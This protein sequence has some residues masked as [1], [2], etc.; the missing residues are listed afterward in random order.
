M[1][2]KF[3]YLLF[4][5]ICLV[6]CTFYFNATSIAQANSNSSFKYYEYD[7]G[8]LSFSV[9][10][11]NSELYKTIYSYDNNGRLLSKKTSKIS[12]VDSPGTVDISAASFDVYA[13]NVPDNA[14]KVQFPTWTE[15]SWQDDLANPWISGVKV[16][17]GVWKVTIPFT[18][19]FK[20]SGNYLTDVYV[21]NVYY[22]GVIT[23]VQQKATKITVPTSVSISEKKYEV[24]VTGVPLQVNR[25]LIPTW[26]EVNGKDDLDW[27]PAVNKGNGTWS[28]VVSLQ[29]HNEDRGN[30]ISHIYYYDKYGNSIGFEEVSVNVT[31]PVVDSIKEVDLAA[32]SF[33]VYV[34]GIA[35]NVQNVSFP[36][37]TAKSGQDD[38][39][40]PWIK[41]TN[42]GNGTWKATI[43]FSKHFNEEGDYLTDVYIDGTF[44]SGTTT[45]VK[46]QTQIIAPSSISL[47]TRYYEVRVTGIPQNITEVK[48]PTWS[49]HNGQDDLEWIPAVNRGHGIWS[50]VVDVA[51]HGN[52]TGPYTSHFY[53]YNDQGHSIGFDGVVVNVN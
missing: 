50:A 8:V 19:H 47:G 45:V 22:G 48:V 28:A 33:D 24:T 17:K 6:T 4:C 18:N 29:K 31:R 38:L 42:M 16:S 10:Q 15:H 51:R 12:R 26:S 1:K 53:Y 30:Y 41:G 49:N 32:A 13:Y 3:G 21:D 27:I 39:E 25:V 7:N 34:Y 52:D 35:P 14:Q 23:K 5:C 40:W 46:K 9:I 20:E 43:P 11:K 37:W 36:T 2:R 44:Y